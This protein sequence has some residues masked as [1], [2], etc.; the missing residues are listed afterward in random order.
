MRNDFGILCNEIFI[1]DDRLV[2]EY[3]LVV[4][5]LIIIRVRKYIGWIFS[6]K[7]I[8]VFVKWLIEYYIFCECFNLSFL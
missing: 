6:K 4:S 3:D 5:G 2:Y 7:V 1:S 8:M